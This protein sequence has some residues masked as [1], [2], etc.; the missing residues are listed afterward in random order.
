MRNLIVLLI[1]LGCGIAR[2]E[3]WPRWLGPRGDGISRETRLAEH[4]PVQ[5]PAK[6]W[7]LPIGEGFSSPVAVEGKIYLFTLVD[8]KRETLQAF[9]AANGKVLWTESYDGGWA[10]AY[11]G[12]R[13]TPVIEN[14]RIYTYGG[15]GDLVAWELGAGKIIWRTNVM[16]QTNVRTNLGWGLSSSPL[17]IG[18]LICVQDGAGGPIAVG[19]NKNTGKIAWQSEARGLGGYAHPILADVSGSRQLIVFGGNAVY[20]MDPASGRTIWQEPWTTKYDVN[21]MTPVYRDGH[22]LISSSYD[23]GAMML[24]LSAGGA[25]RLWAHRDAQHIRSRFPAAVLDGNTLYANS[26]GTLKAMSWPD[27]K[28]LWSNR[29]IRLGPGGSFVRVGDKLITLSER[30]ELMLIKATPQ[31]ATKISS[32]K[33]ADSDRNWSTPLIYQCKLYVKT[34]E[35]LICL[36]ISAK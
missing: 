35:E 21:A 29:Q 13:A 24:Q 28:I 26:E 31:G 34:T 7:S 30:G 16:E 15:K 36:D 18:D 25:N 32:V 10:D 6:L 12:S 11:P 19:L 3:D 14:G 2:A 1:V 5:G 8:Q 4:W 20:G 33:L 27:G 17:I 9:D 23:S 22:L